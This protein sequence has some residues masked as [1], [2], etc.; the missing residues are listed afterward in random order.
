[1]NIVHITTVHGPFDNRIFYK[2]CLSILRKG[3]F[4]TLIAPHENDQNVRGVNIRALPRTKSRIKRI[5]AI[6]YKAYKKAL[7]ENAD[8]YHFHDPEFIPLAW[9]LRLRGKKRIV[10][11]V[12]EDY[13]TLM[14]VKGYLPF[15]LRTVLAF[16]FN[17]FE[18]VLTKRFNKVLAEKYYKK[19]FPDGLTVLNYPG[20]DLLDMPMN[21]RLDQKIRL[22]Y[23]GNI[24]AD[25][26]GVEHANIV[27]YVEEALV[28][29][30]GRCDKDFANKLY[31]IAGDKKDRLYINGVGRFVPFEEIK[32]YYA[33]GNWMAGLAIFPPGDHYINKELTKFFEYMSIGIPVIC[34]GFPVWKKLVE[35]TGA[36]LCVN[37]VDKGEIKSAVKYLYLNREKAEKMGQNGRTSVKSSF[38][39]E[40]EANKLEI[41]Y[42]DLMKE[43]K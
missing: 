27:N 43:S 13:S 18:K 28:Y 22:I 8:I 23:T 16:L 33:E 31:E 11:D 2:E 5:F 26:G 19:R 25:R 40:H 6:N 17:V 35:E 32:K 38:K 12:H 34:S 41:F 14:K 29:L 7:A 3:H 21:S 15:T 1:M 42:Q 36:G 4:V 9:L 10:Y 30:I 37:P 39:W 24:T 20:S